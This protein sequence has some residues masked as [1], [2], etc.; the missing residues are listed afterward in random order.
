M[1]HQNSVFHGLLKHVPWSCF[2]KL[3]DEHG[4]DARVRRLST[5]S[6]FVAL[7]YGQLAGAVS[8]REI[9]TAV[10]SHRARLYHLGARELS[11]STLA[12]ANARRP[13]E[14]FSGL[15]ARMTAMAGRGLRRSTAEAV[16]LIDS[17]G[18]RL[19]GIAC[20]WARFSKGVCGAK[21]H[22]VYDPD[23]QTPL[24]L[25]VTPAKVNDIIAARAIPIEPGAT[26]VFDLGYYDFAWWAKLDAAG[27]RIVSRLK[28]NTPLTLVEERA[29]PE[30]STL[31]YDR[32]GFLPVRQAASRT[33]PFQDP[34]REIGVVLE[35]GATLRV[36]SNDL[37]ATADEIAALYKRRWAIELFFRWVKQTLRIRHF[38]GRSENAVRIQIAVALIAYLLLKLAKDAVRIIDSPLAFARL[39]RTN[40]MHRRDIDKLLKPPKPLQK[41]PRQL[42]FQLT[43]N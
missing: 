13:H 40:L 21:A 2:D 31:S 1:R 10:Q 9:E 12:D 24:Y 43:P 22:I 26:Y 23:A 20:D 4:S 3:V 41:D 27:C 29:L 6:Q 39:V 25:A 18:I 38:I 17:T 42:N 5:R 34:V 16:R 19:S 36:V 7:L 15:F 28:A 14:V 35:D 33:N 30:G 32:L 37:D 8:L 11:R